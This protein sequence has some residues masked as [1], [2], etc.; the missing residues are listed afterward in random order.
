MLRDEY[1]ALR[2]VGTPL[3][4]ISARPAVSGT[5]GRGFRRQIWSQLVIV[6]ASPA[7]ESIVLAPDQR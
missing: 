3:V 7:A 1:E 2:A 5:T 6:Q 4:V